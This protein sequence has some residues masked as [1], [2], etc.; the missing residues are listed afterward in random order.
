[1][2]L[3]LKV[4]GLSVLGVVASSALIYCISVYS[5][6]SKLEVGKGG[7]TLYLNYAVPDK[8]DSDL[9]PYTLFTPQYI[10]LSGEFYNKIQNLSATARV[11]SRLGNVTINFD[12]GT[13]S[14]DIESFTF[15]FIIDPGKKGSNL[16]APDCPCTYT[17]TIFPGIW[18]FKPFKDPFEK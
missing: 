10:T 18:K 15:D 12:G 17:Q 14:S 6:A 8:A 13:I 7:N 5:S 3:N 11:S 1:M 9:S 2:K 4:A 16:S